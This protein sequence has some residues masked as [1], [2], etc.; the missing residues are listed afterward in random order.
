MLYLRLYDSVVDCVI[1]I[2]CK[3]TNA[4]FALYLPFLRNKLRKKK[5]IYHEKLNGF[6]ALCFAYIHTNKEKRK[7]A[8]KYHKLFCIY[9][10]LS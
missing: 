6:Q 8:Q 4:K 1:L 10:L 2:V 9:F 7:E 5:T 3:Q